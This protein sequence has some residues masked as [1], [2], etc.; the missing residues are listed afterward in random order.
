MVKIGKYDYII[1][2]NP[3]KK[4]MVLVDRKV[5]HFGDSKYQHF[6]DK[7]GLL[8]K[9]MAHGDKARRDNYLRRTANI[10]NKLGQKTKDL[11]SSANYHARKVLWAG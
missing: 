3:S 7:T 8:P 5:I 6:K 1:S 9:S 2:T 4:L 11:P 10:T